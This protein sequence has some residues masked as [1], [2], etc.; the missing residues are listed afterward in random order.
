[1]K[2]RCEKSTLDGVVSIARRAAASRSTGLQVL[3]GVRVAVQGN[4]LEVTGTDLELTVR[5]SA[6]VTGL[7]DGAC[8]VPAALVGDIVK[9]FSDGKVEVSLVE[10]EL[11]INW[12]RSSFSVRTM[13]L[14]QFPKMPEPGGLAVSLPAAEVG[15][16][17]R[18]VVR[19]AS[20][21][22]S[23]PILTG[24]RMEAADGGGLRMVAT[25]SYRLAL[26]D[27]AGSGSV[28][29]DSKVL[30]P[31]KALSELARVLGDSGEVDIR[32]GERDVTFSTGTVQVST[33]L[34]EGEF[35]N[36]RQLIPASYPNKL[37][38]GKGALSDAVR[39]MRIMTSDTK[40]IRLRLSAEGV[41]LSAV[42]Q[43]W[44]KGSEFVDGRYE[45]AELVVAFNP[46]YLSA[47]LEGVPTDDVVLET[48]DA[49]K[50]AVLHGSDDSGY[51]YLLMPVR[52]S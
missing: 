31:S 43:E 14:E 10:D 21:D 30:V 50:P 26:S 51:L 28:L 38:I 41:E 17:L 2:F 13:E 35:P 16:A 34:I 18:R 6:E 1:V 46:D 36:Y 27:L 4:R 5:A 33:R 15:Q 52:V 32:L 40:N 8:V 29:S 7:D 48:I 24:V 42:N 3:S 19:A 12:D 9:G 11:V 44:G 20:T 22:E 37:V 23:R 39:R 45:G 25:D 49:M 47:G